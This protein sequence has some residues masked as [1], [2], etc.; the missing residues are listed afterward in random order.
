[1][2]DLT[3][4]KQLFVL[5]VA[6]YLREVHDLNINSTVGVDEL[7]SGFAAWSKRQGGEV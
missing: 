1:M 5:R 7:L 4:E 3:T 2:S 6:R